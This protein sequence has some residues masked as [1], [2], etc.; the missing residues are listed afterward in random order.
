MD[1]DEQPSVVGDYEEIWRGAD[2]IVFSTT[3]E[4]PSSARTSIQRAF[5]PSRIR[6]M[7]ASSARDLSIGGPHLAA[8]AIK[9]GL[10]DEFRFF[11]A[12]VVIGAGNA[13]LPNDVRIDLELSDERRFRSGFVYLAY[14]TR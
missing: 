2:K 13:S 3:L 7:K 12:P 5:D 8:A 6:E 10:V 1:L 9:A 11:L 4:T 14:R